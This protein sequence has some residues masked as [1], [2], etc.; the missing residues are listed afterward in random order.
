MM[1]RE[2]EERNYGGSPHDAVDSVWGSLGG[3]IG[4]VFRAVDSAVSV[5][6][7]SKKKGRF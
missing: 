7:F 1:G 6:S 4:G 2:R 3:A 5:L